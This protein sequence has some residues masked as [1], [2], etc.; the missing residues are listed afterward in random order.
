MAGT[1]RETDMSRTILVPVDGSEHSRKALDFAAELCTGLGAKLSLLNVVQSL[2][3]DRTLV[4]GAAAITVHMTPE[5]LKD[6]GA[7]VLDAAKAQ[8]E[9]DGVQQIETS[10][11]LGDPAHEIVARAKELDAYM[12]VMGSR[13]LSDLAGLFMGSVSHKVLH[14]APCTCV[15]VR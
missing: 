14:L 3:H 12:V 9:N 4:L 7:K 13:G 2:P 8:A 1:S 11:V 6:V 10:V 15:C 5:E